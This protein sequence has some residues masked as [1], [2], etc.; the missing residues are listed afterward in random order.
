MQVCICNSSNDGCM[1]ISAFESCCDSTN[2]KT[3]IGLRSLRTTGEPL[4]VLHAHR[5]QI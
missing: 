1:F 2:V 3:S 5:L 4:F